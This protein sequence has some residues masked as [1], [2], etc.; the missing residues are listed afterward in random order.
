MDRV[1][2]EFLAASAL[3]DD[4]NGRFGG[5]NFLDHP[6]DLAHLRRGTVH[7]SETVRGWR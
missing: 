3:A 1:C 7:Q 6:V 2:N 4:E 5:R